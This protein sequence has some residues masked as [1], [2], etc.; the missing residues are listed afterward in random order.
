MPVLLPFIT[1][2]ERR[3]SRVNNTAHLVSSYVNSHWRNNNCLGTGAEINRSTKG[4]EK[5]GVEGGEEWGEGIPSPAD[6]GVW[7]SVVISTA[8]NDL[9][10]F[11]GVT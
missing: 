11:L 4:T 1:G 9:Y 2:Y 10:R 5:W 6:Y 3:M 7:V 8:E